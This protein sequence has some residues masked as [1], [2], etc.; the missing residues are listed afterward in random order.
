[1]SLKDLHPGGLYIILFVQDSP[2]ELDQFHWGLYVH[3]D[4]NKGGTKHHIKGLLSGG[5]IPDRGVTMGVF[6]S[7]LLVGLF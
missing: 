7:S 2:P 3:I 6:K 1:M 4:E 5:W